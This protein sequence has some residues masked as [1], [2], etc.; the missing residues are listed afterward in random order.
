MISLAPP[1]ALYVMMHHDRSGP[2]LFIATKKLTIV[3]DYLTWC[4][5]NTK[6]SK[7]KQATHA[8]DQVE[9]LG[10]ARQVSQLTSYVGREPD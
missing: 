9:S 1:G 3:S 6:N 8:N 2:S 7:I 10:W 5:H 4:M